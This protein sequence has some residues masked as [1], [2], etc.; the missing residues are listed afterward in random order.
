M[1][2]T[3]DYLDVH[4]NDHSNRRLSGS[5]D[6]ANFF[7]GS[8]WRLDQ[9]FYDNQKSSSTFITRGS[10]TGP[11][12]VFHLLWLQLP[13]DQLSHNTSAVGS[14]ASFTILNLRWLQFTPSNGQVTGTRLL[15]VLPSFYHCW[16]FR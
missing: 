10:V 12:I 3:G 8:I 4:G 1:P 16:I 9:G 13:L 7:S 14:P 5:M 6:E 2:A 15:P 11:R